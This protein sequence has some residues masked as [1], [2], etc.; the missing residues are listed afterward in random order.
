MMIEKIRML[1]NAEKANPYVAV[2]SG[3]NTFIKMKKP[4]VTNEEIANAEDNSFEILGSN[5]FLS[6]ILSP[7]AKFA[8]ILPHDIRLFQ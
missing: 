8:I 4:K 6:F 5:N 3:L 7:L 1:I 2:P